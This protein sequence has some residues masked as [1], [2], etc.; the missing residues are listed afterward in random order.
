MRRGPHRCW[1]RELGACSWCES[2][3]EDRRE[4]REEPVSEGEAA[5]LDNWYEQQMDR[6]AEL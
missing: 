5:A 3:A 6:M 4:A 1:D 2:R